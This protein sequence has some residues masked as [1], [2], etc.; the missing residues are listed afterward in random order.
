MVLVNVL[1][2]KDE[3]LDEPFLNEPF[4][5]TFKLGNGDTVTTKFMEAEDIKI[6]YKELKDAEIVSLPFKNN[7]Y[8][9]VIVA[10][11]NDS[12]EKHFK[13]LSRLK[14]RLFIHNYNFCYMC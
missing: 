8:S 10:P 12:G 3:W 1:Y 13:L 14:H 6:G 2:F 4:D 9:M 5:D 11:K 7:D